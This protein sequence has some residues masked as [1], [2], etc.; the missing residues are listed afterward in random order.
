MKDKPKLE[1]YIFN[2]FSGYDILATKE[3]KVIGN[4]SSII[5]NVLQDHIG[6]YSISGTLY[7][8]DSE[9]DFLTDTFDVTIVLLTHDGL[10]KKA[11]VG[12]IY[13]VSQDNKLVYNFIAGKY[14]PLK[15]EK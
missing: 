3:D 1:T 2:T 6:K 5:I 11:Y 14:I 10:Y 13:L 7:F 15:E 12:D 8:R 4:V 9:N